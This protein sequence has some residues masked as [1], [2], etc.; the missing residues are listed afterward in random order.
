MKLDCP[1]LLFH[2]IKE[3]HFIFRAKLILGMALLADF[4]E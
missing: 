4:N 1:S 3:S 2:F